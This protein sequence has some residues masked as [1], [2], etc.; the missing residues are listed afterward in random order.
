[1]NEVRCAHLRSW[2][3]YPTSTHNVLC[4]SVSGEVCTG[5]ES[6]LPVFID[7][8]ECGSTVISL[9][10]EGDLI[11][12][13]LEADQEGSYNIG[14]KVN[15][16]IN[17]GTHH[18]VLISDIEGQDIAPSRNILLDGDCIELGVNELGRV[19]IAVH[20]NHH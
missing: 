19:G 6:D 13:G 20:L 15:A 14:G 11:E 4:F 3:G 7:F 12:W 18:C 16:R 2:G 8:E 9:D 17:R 1:M 5:L 10:L